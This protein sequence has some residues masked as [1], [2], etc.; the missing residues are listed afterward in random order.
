M[1]MT[2][3]G[4]TTERLLERITQEFP[5]VKWTSARIEDEGWDHFAVILDNSVVFRIPKTEEKRG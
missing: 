1:Y 2:T 4:N 5:D 3:D